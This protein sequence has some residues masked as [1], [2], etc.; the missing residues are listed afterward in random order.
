[1]EETQSFDDFATQCYLENIA[2]ACSLLASN[3]SIYKQDH[4]FLF[5]DLCSQKK[6]DVVT[7]VLFQ[8]NLILSDEIALCFYISCLTQDTDTIE[9]LW[10]S[11]HMNRNDLH[12]YQD[13]LFLNFYLH[14]QQFDVRIADFMW[15]HGILPRTNIVNNIVA[16]FQAACLEYSWTTLASFAN[17]EHVPK[18]AYRA[19]NN[20]AFCAAADKHDDKTIRF[21]WDMGVVTKHDTSVIRCALGHACANHRSRVRRFLLRLNVLDQ[22]DIRAAQRDGQLFANAHAERLTALN[23]LRRDLEIV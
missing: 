9:Y 13:N 3:A 14:S 7:N 23:D 16:A 21:L 1:M 12:P 4:R 19:N 18:K 11:P 17:Y 8:H 20:F 15:R 2:K 22:R 10:N 6:F 5:E